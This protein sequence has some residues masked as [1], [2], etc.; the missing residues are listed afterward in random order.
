MTSS[1]GSLPEGDRD[2]VLFNELTKVLEKIIEQLPPQRRMIFRLNRF[3][4]MTY[5]AIASK[6]K[7]TENTVDTQIRRAL[8]H[9]RKEYGKYL[10]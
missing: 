4:S 6:L 9:I 10:K 5:K 3:Y 8:D 7:I 1:S 2:E